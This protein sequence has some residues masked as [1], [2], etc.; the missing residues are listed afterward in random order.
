[1][2][3]FVHLLQEVVQEA[4]IRKAQ[5]FS[6]RNA[7]ELP[8]FYRP[9]KNWDWIVVADKQ[10]LAVL[11][12]KSQVGPS[13]GNNFNNRV[14]E[15]LG[16]ATDLWKAC[17]EGTFALS[18]RPWVGFLMLLEDCP[19]STTPVRVDEPQFPVRSE[20]W[21]ESYSREL[22]PIGVS[23]AKRYDLF[24]RK[25]VRDRLYDA[26]CLML[27]TSTGGVK[28]IFSEPASD[29]T[30]ATFVASLLGRVTEHTKLKQLGDQP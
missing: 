29:L 13:F 7:S 2:D 24:C 11:E 6:G 14:E 30:F 8:G 20:F 9:T 10:L 17:A 1:M 28:G 21:H 3:G 18:P 12:L 23:Y 4:G 15:A 25:I 26:A 5:I 19:G 22:S 27:S 16:N